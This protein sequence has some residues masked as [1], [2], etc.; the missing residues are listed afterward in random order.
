MT[1]LRRL[2]TLGAA[3]TPLLVVTLVLGVVLLVPAESFA[4]QKGKKEQEA[5]PSK[6]YTMQYFITG[7][8]VFLIA[9]PLCWPA[10]RR[11]D[12][13]FHEDE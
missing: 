2:L 8:A 4:Q 3:R 11:W 7:M 10:L 13:P 9:A 12:L 6:G 5:P 1:M